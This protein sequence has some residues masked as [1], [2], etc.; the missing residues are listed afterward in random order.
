MLIKKSEEIIFLIN[1]HISYIGLSNNNG[2]NG[3][4][5]PYKAKTSEG[6]KEFNDMGDVED[7]LLA[8]AHESEQQGFNV[9]EAVWLEHF[10]FCN[11][12][13]LVNRESQALIKSY[14]YCQESNTPP[15]E[16]L[17]KTPA[18]FINNWMIVRDELT[19]IRN[20]DAKERQNAK[21]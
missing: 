6:V 19:H 10:Y 4:K 5:F 8:V 7:E 11:S 3:F 16:S 15:Y 13:D 14:L 1:I 18:N 9:G 20:L 17:A 2:D 12:S 21:K